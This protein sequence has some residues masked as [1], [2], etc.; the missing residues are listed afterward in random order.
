MTHRRPVSLIAL[1]LVLVS[2][3]ALARA[4]AAATTKPRSYVPPPV[5]SLEPA[6]TA[7]LWRKLVATRDQRA[8]RSQRAA[9]CRP[10]RAVFWAATDWLRLATK[11][12]AAASPCGQYYI[13]V[14]P[15]VGNKTTIRSGA[16]SRIRAL[17]PNFHAL[18]EIH[19]TA[20]S[21]WVASTGS[22]WYTAG[23]TA[24][25]RMAAAGFDVT[26]G[27]TWVVNE[28]STA[29]RRGTGNARAN[30][31]EL[32]RGLYDGDG[33]HPTRGGVLIVGV[34]QQT[35]DTSLYQT[36]LQNWY[37]DSAF[38]TDMS[39]YVSDWSQEV[40][41]DV[42]NYAV[43]GAPLEVRR[44]YL[45]DYLQHQ[46]VLSQAAPPTIEPA[47]TYLASAYSPLANAAWQRESGYGWTMV[48]VDL[49][50]SFVSA[51]VYA[52]R[53]FSAANAE[54]QDHWG[55]AW[56]PRNGTALAAAD[57]AT[58]SGAILDRL[59]AA[60]RDSADAVDPEDPGSA[61]CAPSGQ[62]QWCVGDVDGARLNPAWQ[63]FRTW[64]QP[65][66]SFATPPQTIP[67]G[68]PSAAISLA[69][70]NARGGPQT[71]LT[72]ITVTVSSSSPQGTFSTSPTGPWSPSLSLTIAAG[73]STAG[74]FY[75]LDTRAGA[76]TITA[77][78]F[79]VTSGTQIIT[80]LPGAPV[81]VSIAPRSMPVPVRTTK[82]LTALAADSFGNR[83][84]TLAS[85]SLS[86]EARGTLST[87]TGNSTTF[88]ASRRIGRGTVTAS[89]DTGSGTL[90]AAANV[91]VVPSPMHVALRYQARKRAFFA[92]L[93]ATDPAGQSVSRARIAIVVRR[94]GRVYFSKTATTGAAGRV[95]V[96][97]LARK[98]GCFTTTVMRAT[99]LG[100][101]WDRRMSQNRICR[102]RSR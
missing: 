22:S 63:S 28:L 16:A 15:I 101:T 26:K 72:P 65:L 10:L 100:F 23:V 53:H 76:Q 90:S 80:V 62:I 79:G 8:Q 97:V 4:G 61:A 7:K 86:P 84:P 78:A 43:P 40:Y 36:N 31:R 88:T 5:A 57:F 95:S 33:A 96:R 39:K 67:A 70:L 91:N 75:Y 45:N 42:R 6:A 38:W 56:A 60:I 93:L 73:A 44:D 13:S 9:D 64:T 55:F 89:V 99:A 82:E 30:V 58:Q 14:P 48:P 25:E 21:N 49:M 27:D 98:G 41:G 32:L 47:K 83:F 52:M 34:G 12:A 18:A 37:S 87:T 51:Q 102:P 59:A 29:V 77:S 1:A 11:L 74:P 24:R 94:K 92:S 81:S 66:L 46:I 3:T 54:P 68:T 19:F 69:L 71:A 50:E 2:A 17:G 85:W 20:W 35:T